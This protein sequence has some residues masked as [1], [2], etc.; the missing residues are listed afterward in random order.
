V[1]GLVSAGLLLTGCGQLSY[2]SQSVRGQLELMGKRR[3]ITEVAGD[4]ATSDEVRNKLLEIIRIRQF[5]S[6]ELNLPDNDSYRIYAD[7]QRPFAVWNVFAAPEFSLEPK[8]WCFVFVGCLAYRGY[9]DERDAR[10][11]AARQRQEGMDVVVSGI[12]AYS[13]LGWFDDPILNTFMDL[14]RHRLAGLVFHELAHQQLY[15]DDDSAFNESFATAVQLA[16]VRRYLQRFGNAHERR[17]HEL[18]MARQVEFLSLV[19]TARSRLR[20][21]YQR[22]L[23]PEKMRVEKEAQIEALRR[24]Y[25]RLRERWGGYRG[26]DAW[27]ARDLNN[28]KLAAVATY[29]HYVPAFELLLRQQQGRFDR[30]YRAAKALG[31]FPLNERRNRMDL[32]LAEAA[33]GQ[34]SVATHRNARSGSEPPSTAAQPNRLP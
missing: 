15:I 22:P 31:E 14:P 30:F 1:I 8:Q 34:R 23:A 3:P 18:A 20:Q 13:T 32:L 10:R 4:E 7:L 11:F 33:N 2:Y 24:A 12:R 5:A 19:D 17:A 25:E 27:F 21:L 16:G 9:F 26:Y 6:D 29:Q 28:A